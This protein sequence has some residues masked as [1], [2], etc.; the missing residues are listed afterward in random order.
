LVRV[1][2]TYKGTVQGVGFRYTAKALAERIGGIGGYV[3]N[4]PQGTVE[5]VCEG[6][7]DDLDEFISRISERMG[8]YISDVDIVRDECPKDGYSTFDIRI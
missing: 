7:K 5:M 1:R 8:G 2:A 3:R 4:T 6:Q